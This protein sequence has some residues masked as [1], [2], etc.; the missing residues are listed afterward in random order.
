[1]K[2]FDLQNTIFLMLFVTLLKF[3]YVKKTLFPDYK[4]NNIFLQR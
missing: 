4:N 2:R 1:M 3:C